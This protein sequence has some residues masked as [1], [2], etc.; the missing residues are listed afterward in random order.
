LGVRHYALYR[1]HGADGRKI[2][3]T[4]DGGGAP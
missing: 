3:L 2:E 1:R 4:P